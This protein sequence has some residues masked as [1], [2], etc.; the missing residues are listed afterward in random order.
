MTEC[1]QKCWG[2]WL[3]L[4]WNRSGLSLK[5]M[6][7]VEGPQK[8]KGSQYHSCLQKGQER[9]GEQQVGQPNFSSWERTK[10][11]CW[12]GMAAKLD[13]A[14]I[15]RDLVN[16]GSWVERN[17]MKFINRKCQIPHLGSSY[18]RHQDTL[19][20]V[21]LKSSSAGKCRGIWLD[22]KLIMGER[23]ALVAKG[24]N[25]TLGHIKRMVANRSRKI[26]S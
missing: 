12:R 26:N 14:T 1:T 23:C 20:A 2:I 8:I 16:L 5:V 10:S 3:I 25:S 15:Q 19:N 13:G 24:S 9:S 6:V 7:S 18:H 22:K 4:L 21:C 11:I 17:L